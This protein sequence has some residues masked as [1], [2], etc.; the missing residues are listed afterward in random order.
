MRYLGNKT[1]LL[2]FIAG[3]IE[4]YH[5]EGKV[6]ADLFAGTGSVGDHFKDKYHIISNDYMYFSTVISGAKLLNARVPDFS[7]FVN[8][9]G[10]DPFDY[11]NNKKYEP[12]DHFFIYNNYTPKAERMFFTENNAVRIDGIRIDLEEAYKNGFLLYNEYVFVLASLLESILRISN[13]SGTYQAFFK[14]WE[15]R[16]LKSFL[17][18]PLAFNKKTLCG[19]EQNML[20]N[21]D[22]NLAARHISGDIAY[23]DPPYTTTQFA[24]M[25]HVLETVARY[26]YPEL[27][28]KTGRRVNRSLSGYSNKQMV[29][30]EFEDLFR[31]LD[32]KDILISY[33]NQSLIPLDE[34]VALAAK[35]AVDGE[36][37]IEKFKYREYATNN[38]SSKDE[39]DGLNEAII[40]FRKNRQ[41]NKSPLNYSGSKNE[42]L[43]ALIKEL[44]KHL[45][46]FVDTMGGAFNVGAN[47]VAIEK[48]VYNEYNPFVFNIVKMLIEKDKKAIVGDTKKLIKEYKL[49]KKNQ[50]AYLR[51][52]DYY[53]NGNSDSS[54]LFTLQIYS[55]QNIIR[56][57]SNLKMNTPVG[58]NEYNAGTEGRI[59]AFQPKTEKVE[60]LNGKYQTLDIEKY[61][62]NTVFYFDPPYFLTTAEYNDGKRGFEGWDADKETELLQFLNKIDNSGRKFMLSNVLQ[63]KGKKHHMLEEWIKHHDYRV[64]VVGETGI[65]YPRTEILV[66]N[67]DIKGGY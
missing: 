46:V 31:Q 17:L 10:V 51:L 12:G 26:D 21:E 61:P 4:K 36:V 6:F 58:N 2:E 56:F 44:P 15:K 59:F 9:F 20:L 50:N 19:K 24:N 57:N 52:R 65:K 49:H 25:Y 40:Y 37:H 7:R 3:V 64:V 33:S 30:S 5:I 60:L 48:V 55:F 41:I 42:I 32:F 13:T 11:F 53:N 47:I 45:E 29:L 27:F 67:Y 28:G 14:F 1:K 35:F 23:L 34:M 66:M 39:G 63:H 62:T 16:S 43:P 38:L 18:E 54:V 22:V 8:R